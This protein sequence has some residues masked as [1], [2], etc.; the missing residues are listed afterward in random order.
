MSA[1]NRDGSS[2]ARIAAIHAYKTILRDV[3]DKRPSGSRQRLATSLGKARSFI[4]QIT[5]P[6]YGIAIPAQHLPLIFEV[7]HF[8]A[9]EKKEFMAA[10]QTAHPRHWPIADQAPRLRTIQLAV[11]DLGDEAEN[12]A[13][14]RL[15]SDFIAGVAKV[16][17]KSGRKS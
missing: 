8:S 9:S 11:P 13:F 14:D 12:K 10:Y 2:A 15:I 3:L 16:G 5:N 7:C 1:R 6:A 17:F 4:S